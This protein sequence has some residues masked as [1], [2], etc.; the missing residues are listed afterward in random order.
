MYIYNIFRKILCPL[1]PYLLLPPYLLFTFN[2]L[3]MW[4]GKRNTIKTFPSNNV[5]IETQGA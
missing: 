2:F 3:T 4:I 1:L 5:D